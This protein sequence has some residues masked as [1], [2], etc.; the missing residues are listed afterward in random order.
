MIDS[1]AGT[2]RFPPSDVLDAY[3]SRSSRSSG[4]LLWVALGL[5]M[6]PVIAALLKTDVQNVRLGALLVLSPIGLVVLLRMLPDEIRTEYLFRELRRYEATA[7]Q[8]LAYAHM[9]RVDNLRRKTWLGRRFGSPDET[10]QK[11]KRTRQLR[12]REDEMPVSNT[13]AP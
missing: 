3:G 5:G 4:P 13:E 1:K 2:W 9:D 8:E 11:P 12:K 7:G 10:V 6:L